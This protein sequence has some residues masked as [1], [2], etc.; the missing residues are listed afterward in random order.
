MKKIFSTI[1]VAFFL[2]VVCLQVKAQDASPV[3]PPAYTVAAGNYVRTWDV[4]LPQATTNNITA[5]SAIPAYNMTTRYFDGLG[6]LLQTVVKQGS[7]PTGAAAS[8]NVSPIVYD[9]YGREN[10]QYLSFAANTTGGN[11]S[12]SDGLFKL[13][14]F[15]QQ[16]FFYSNSNSPVSGQ[17]ETFYYSKTDFE[18]SPLNRINKTYPAG[19]SWVNAG[20][21]VAK[22]YWTNTVTDSVKYFTVTD[23]AGG[24]ATMPVVVIMLL[25]TFPK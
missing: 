14:P 11:T 8:D 3:L 22:K 18:A 15:A 19:N 20:R 2:L 10:R 7:M 1:K 23:V 6:R 4:A 9:D 12:V 13:N 25:V 16:Q 21:G 24:W 5:S 17:G